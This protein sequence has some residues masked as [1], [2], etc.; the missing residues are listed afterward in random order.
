MNVATAELATQAAA[1][2]EV[3]DSYTTAVDRFIDEGGAEPNWTAMYFRLSAEVR[4][5]AAD[6]SDLTA[7]ATGSERAA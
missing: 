3:A 5:L 1:A 2:R 4:Q 7:T 6:L